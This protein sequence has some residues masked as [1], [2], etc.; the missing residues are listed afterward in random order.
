MQR[1]KQMHAVLVLHV[2]SRAGERK[3]SQLR[4]LHTVHVSWSKL[5]SSF[6]PFIHMYDS[7]IMFRFFDAFFNSTF[8]KS[9]TYRDYIPWAIQLYLK[10]SCKIS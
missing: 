10:I 2:N 1:G 3:G 4:K 6:G 9:L 5:F 7:H 8:L